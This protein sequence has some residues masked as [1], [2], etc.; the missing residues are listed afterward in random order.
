MNDTNAIIQ[1][2]NNKIRGRHTLRKV[3]ELIYRIPGSSA[4]MGMAEDGLPVLWNTNAGASNIVVWNKMAKQGLRILKVIA[5]YLFS[6]HKEVGVKAEQI[7]FVVLTCYPNDW[8]ELNDYG[9]GTNE[10]TILKG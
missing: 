6:Y 4:L 7:E 3:V 8:G 1:V 9:F 2:M 10:K 5:E